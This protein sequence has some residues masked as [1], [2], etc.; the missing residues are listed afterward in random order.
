M[1]G[2][3]LSAALETDNLVCM[4]VFELSLVLFAYFVDPRNGKQNR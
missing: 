1:I 3:D 4:Y 2:E